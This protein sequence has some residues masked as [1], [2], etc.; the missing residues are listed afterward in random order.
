MNL[1]CLFVHILP[2]HFES[3]FH[4]IWI[5]GLF[6]PYLKCD[7]PHKKYICT[8]NVYEINLNSCMKMR[9]QTYILVLSGMQRTAVLNFD[10]K[11]G[12]HMVQY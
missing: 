5:L 6:W 12:P 8:Y 4:E 3:H 10:F 11:G 2:S 9:L 7:D 1:I